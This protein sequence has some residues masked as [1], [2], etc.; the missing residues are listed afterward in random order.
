M[1]YIF[2]F[3][4]L[5]GAIGLFLYGMKLMSEGLQKITGNKLRAVLNLM[6]SSRFKA[7]SGGFLIAA[8]V[9]ASSVVSVITVSFVNSGMLSLSESIGVIMGANIGATLKIWLIS[10]FGLNTGMGIIALPLIGLAFPLLFSKNNL[11]K[12]W[13]EVGI[14]IAL[15]FAGIDFLNFLFLNFHHY[16]FI[17]TTLIDFS[18]NG[19]GTI[20]L[21]FCLSLIITALIRSSSAVI[22]LA[23]VMCSNKYLSFEIGAAI[24]LGANIGTTVTANIAALAANVFG[25]RTALSNTLINITGVILVFAFFKIFLNVTDFI[26]ESIQGNHPLSEYIAMPLGLAVFH[27]LFNITNTIILA[28]FIPLIAKLTESII[29]TKSKADEAYTLKYIGSQFSSSELTFLEAKKEIVSYSR[30][31]R[32]IFSLIPE[33]LIEKDEKKF[34]GL[35]EKVKIQEDMMD[36]VE[37]EINKYLNQIYQGELS[38]KGLKKVKSIQRMAKELENIGDSTFHMAKSLNRKKKENIS[39]TDEQRENLKKMYDLLYKAFDVL[40]EN[41][42]NDYDKVSINKAQL[43]ELRIDKLRNDMMKEHF[44]MAASPEY[45]NK[46]GVIYADLISASEKMADHIYN[47]HEAISGLK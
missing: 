20:I 28:G 27:T 44:E 40:I 12:C 1:E 21:F 23:I 37:E 31:G 22:V 5:L 16:S 25:K 38:E 36:R 9:Q 32:K 39:F 15:L 45:D 47:I 19:F 14:G 2:D 6:A 35:F 13:G 4:S 30:R 11:R 34:A 7:I 46:S 33:M 3:L 43:L 18:G 41:L 42:E 17:I 24:I 10:A 29:P 26:T 8:I